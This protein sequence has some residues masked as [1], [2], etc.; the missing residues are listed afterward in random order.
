MPLKYFVELTLSPNFGN[1]LCAHWLCLVSFSFCSGKCCAAADRITFRLSVSIQVFR[2]A[3]YWLWEPIE[4]FCFI[5]KTLQR[6]KIWHSYLSHATP[7]PYPPH[8]WVT[9]STGSFP[10]KSGNNTCSLMTTGDFIWLL[11]FCMST[12]PP[13]IV[14]FTASVSNK[15]ELPMRLRLSTSRVEHQRPKMIK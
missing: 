12:Y 1:H 10:P 7:L 9:F 2:M 15:T 5:F 6:S 14:S 13:R 11:C 3:L 8:L 4:L